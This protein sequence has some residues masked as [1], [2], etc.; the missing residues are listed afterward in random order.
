MEGPD[1]PEQDD[2]EGVKGRAMCVG[3]RRR[4]ERSKRAARDTQ[5]AAP[6][7]DMARAVAAARESIARVSDASATDRGT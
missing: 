3:A 1:E 6:R 7:P 2:R 4:R 5:G